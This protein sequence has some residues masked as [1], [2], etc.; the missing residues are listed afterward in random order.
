MAID[1]ETK[2]S[3]GGVLFDQPFKIR[4]LGHFGI[5][6]YRMSEAL[7]V[8]NDLLGF[9]IPDNRGM[10]PEK[11]PSAFKEFCDLH[12]YFFRYAGDHLA[13]VLY[14]HRLRKAPDRTGFHKD[15]VTIN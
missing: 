2:Y 9:L 6:A 3:V 15:D 7:H 8:Y 13:F 12:G 1:T 5:N 14:N 10:T 4:R 11:A